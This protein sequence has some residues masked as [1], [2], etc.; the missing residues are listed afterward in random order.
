MSML[1]GGETLLAVSLFRVLTVFSF[2]FVLLKLATRV[3]RLQLDC[4]SPKFTATKFVTKTLNLALCF[5]GS[6]FSGSNLI[7]SNNPLCLETSNL[8]SL[9]FR[10]VQTQYFDSF[11]A[12]FFLGRLAVV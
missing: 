2:H 1:L 3:P 6:G 11:L 12:F 5:W 7:G 10:Q 9:W 4:T 8:Y